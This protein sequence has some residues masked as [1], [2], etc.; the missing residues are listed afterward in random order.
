MAVYEHRTDGP[1]QI[2]V[3]G[4]GT[5][6]AG[7]DLQAS[8]LGRLVAE[9]GNILLCGG[10]GGIMKAAARG[11]KEAGG[12]TI[13]IVPGAE[14]FQANSCID[15]EIVTNLGHL[16][17]FLII[18]S[19]DGVV[20]LPGSY[21]TQAEISIAM[22]LGKPL[23]AISQHWHFIPEVHCYLNPEVAFRALLKQL[24]QKP[25]TDEKKFA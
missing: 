25:G 24:G 6:E 5:S 3:I 19:A 1:W 18:H 13:G 23:V 14:R 9:S 20:A 12:T 22:K 7:L 15:Y 16:R 8:H 2:A 17:N 4:A 11:A 10:L 21:G